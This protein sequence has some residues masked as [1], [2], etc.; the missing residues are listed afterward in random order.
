MRKVL[1]AARDRPA[2]SKVAAHTRTIDTGYQRQRPH[3]APLVPTRRSCAFASRATRTLCS[4]HDFRKLL[5]RPLDRGQKAKKLCQ[6][7]VAN[8]ARAFFRQLF[9]CFQLLVCQKKHCVVPFF[10]SI[11]EAEVPP[12]KNK[13]QGSQKHDQG[14]ASKF[15]SSTFY[16]FLLLAGGGSCCCCCCCC[17]CC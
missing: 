5:T 9:H 7:P 14:K 11:V 6:K 2:I 10:G 8:L 4:V 16:F 13:L 17:C 3:L 12:Q 15:L 1:I